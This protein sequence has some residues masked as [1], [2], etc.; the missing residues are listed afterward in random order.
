MIGTQTV[1]HTGIRLGLLA[2]AMKSVNDATVAS[3]LL[4]RIIDEAVAEQGLAG[5]TIYGM[6]AG[7]AV[8]KMIVHIDYDEH[9]CR[10]QTEGDQVPDFLRRRG[11]E[12]VERESEMAKLFGR[13]AVECARWRTAVSLFSESIRNAGLTMHWS[14]VF[15]RNS[16]AYCDRFGLVSS[17]IAEDYGDAAACTIPNSVFSELSAVFRLSSRVWPKV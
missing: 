2:C 1:T 15:S 10:V 4:G 14:V 11:Q 5:F 17:A 7:V 3:A 13:D 9:A 6:Q 8:A 12:C 16:D